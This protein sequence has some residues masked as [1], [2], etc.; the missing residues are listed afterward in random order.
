MTGRE[1]TRPLWAMSRLYLPSSA[2][3][4]AVIVMVGLG[5][6]DAAGAADWRHRAV[7]R[8]PAMVCVRGGEI[9]LEPRD[10]DPYGPAPER[11]VGSAD[12]VHAAR[13]GR[14]GSFQH[15][16][17]Y[18]DDR[19][20]KEIADAMADWNAPP[21]KKGVK[22]ERIMSKVGQF[23]VSDFSSFAPSFSSPGCYAEFNAGPSTDWSAA[24]G[25]AAE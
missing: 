6:D 11:V 9:P 13:R 16:Y 7:D 12:P 10:R 20:I 15:N 17:Y 2:N 24:P 5:A 25:A 21:A 3:V 4:A 23:G 19:I 18:A 8:P 22:V 14:S 1:R